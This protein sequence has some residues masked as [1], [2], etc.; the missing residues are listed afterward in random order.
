MTVTFI[1]AQPVDYLVPY[2]EPVQLHVQCQATGNY[3]LYFGLKPESIDP[4]AYDWDMGELYG[5]FPASQTEIILSRYVPDEWEPPADTRWLFQALVSY[6]ETGYTEAYLLSDIMRNAFSYGA[7]LLRHLRINI[8]GEGTTTPAPLPEAHTYYKGTEVIVTAIP[9]SG[10]K[11]DHW[12]GDASGTS[13]SITLIMDMDKELW[14]YFVEIPDNGE[15]PPDDNGEPPHDED[16]ETWW[17]K[18]WKWIQENPGYAVGAGGIL[19]VA[20]LWLRRK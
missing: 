7:P 9:S 8:S 12:G 19:V 14:A 16:E 5:P 4:Y 1:S 10:W 13:T 18:I 2:G 6:N 15:P 20:A 11:F 3:W 17:D